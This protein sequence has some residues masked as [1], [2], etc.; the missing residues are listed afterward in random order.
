M[1][2]TSKERAMAAWKLEQAE[3]NLSVSALTKKAV[4]AKELDEA[5]T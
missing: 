5:A 1:T 4:L 3:T 2:V